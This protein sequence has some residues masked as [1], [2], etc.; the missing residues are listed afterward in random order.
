MAPVRKVLIIE[1][2]SLMR[3]QVKQILERE[4]FMVLELTNA[5]EYFS[6]IWQYT[7]I[8]IILLDI[9]LP[10]MDGLAAL[11]KMNSQGTVSWPPVIILSG[12]S[13]KNIIQSALLLGASSYILKPL[14]EMELLQKVNYLCDNPPP[15]K[16]EQRYFEVVAFLKETVNGYINSNFKKFPFQ[17][18]NQLL[19]E[20]MEVVDYEEIM[21][22][23]HRGTSMEEYSLRHTIN[24]A[25]LS[26]IIGKWVGFKENG[27]RDL[28]LAGLLHDFGKVKIPQELLFKSGAVSQLEKKALQA[29]VIHSYDAINIEMF[30]KEV[31]LG[32]LQHHE[33]MDGSG[34]PQKLLGR[35]ICMTARVIAVA[36]VYDAMISN[37]VY[38]KAETPFMVFEE[39]F[40]EMFG[41]LD[42][43]ICTV[44]LKHMKEC[45][46]GQV[47]FLSD[48]SQ[49]KVIDI[50]E[51]GF[52]GPVLR[53]Q[54]GKQI[55]STM[56]NIVGFMPS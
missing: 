38:R 12:C 36:D 51:Q 42:P 2:S 4:G 54:D 40:R 27:I 23:F 10:G 56:V 11:E 50:E 37:K 22:L 25:I 48:G 33:R 13:D 44:F 21:I 52:A 31:L 6:L 26:G 34:Y 9:N 3:L 28:V 5:E 45:L 32:V 15:K 35:E 46:V 55:D 47:V 49:A 43:H 41:K 20:C 29:H 18:I 30:P 7:D 53:T 24:V 19:D 1:D 8:E 17:K 39:L 16:F 14:A